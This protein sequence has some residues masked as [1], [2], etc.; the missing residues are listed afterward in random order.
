[1]LYFAMRASRAVSHCAIALAVPGRLLAR[2]CRASCA[3]IESSE[4]TAHLANGEL[5]L[6]VESHFVAS[7]SI[8]VVR[9]TVDNVLDWFFDSEQGES[10]NRSMRPVYYR[11][12]YL[13]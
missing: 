3:Q 4:C 8:S 11:N 2:A 9:P 6:Q 10:S 7:T 1:M 12:L 13:A 5:R